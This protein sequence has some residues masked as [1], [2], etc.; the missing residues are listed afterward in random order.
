MEEAMNPEEPGAT[1]FTIYIPK[2]L[3]EYSISEL[4]MVPMAM[5]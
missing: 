1:T 3:Q 2:F 5:L 4:A